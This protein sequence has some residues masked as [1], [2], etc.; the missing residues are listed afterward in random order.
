MWK[1]FAIIC[2]GISIAL[3]VFGLPQYL[4]EI[5]E[6]EETWRC[7]LSLVANMID[8][9][10]ARWGF[11][12]VGLIAIAAIHFWPRFRP[13]R[14]VSEPNPVQESTPLSEVIMRVAGHSWDTETAIH[15]ITP[16][17]PK[18][19]SRLENTWQDAWDRIRDLARAGHLRISGRKQFPDA[20]LAARS[21]PLEP[22]CAD[23]W[24]NATIHPGESA[25]GIE[26]PDIV[27]TSTLENQSDFVPYADLLID[28]KDA[29][30]QMLDSFYRRGI[31]LRDGFGWRMGEWNQRWVSNVQ[32]FFDQ[33][34]PGYARKFS[35]ATDGIPLANRQVE[36]V[37][38]NQHF[39][40]FRELMESAES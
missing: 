14:I 4:K 6:N 35:R 38:M 13:K 11:L 31:Q 18:E 15:A 22:I 8:Q 34:L 16:K 32:S 10:F 40:V 27:E 17:D 19:I 29:V 28:R 1:K 36:S 20:D 21:G 24:S 7:W 23:Y 9:D 12:F 26:A 33:E 25:F 3:G 37:M 30:Q 2:S 5:S 39:K